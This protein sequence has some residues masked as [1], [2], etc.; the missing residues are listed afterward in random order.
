MRACAVQPL[1]KKESRTI[2]FRGLTVFGVA[3]VEGRY[4]GVS[5]EQFSGLKRFAFRGFAC[6][7]FQETG[8]CG[9]AGSLLDRFQGQRY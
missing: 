1:K 4:F 9:F 3:G 7:G 6:L 8:V 5:C 2:K